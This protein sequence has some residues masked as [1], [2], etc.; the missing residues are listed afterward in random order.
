MHRRLRRSVRCHWIRKS[1]PCWMDMAMDLWFRK[2][3]IGL[4]KEADAALRGNDKAAS[5]VHHFV[6]RPA[7]SALSALSFAAYGSRISGCFLHPFPVGRLP[8]QG[9]A[10][11][12]LLHPGL[13]SFPDIYCYLITEWTRP[14]S[15]LV[16]TWYGAAMP[17]RGREASGRCPGR[18]SAVRREAPSGSLRR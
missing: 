6:A 11:Q 5:A 17:R 7:T 10:A 16:L 18:A 9:L 1:N 15:G 13:T 14:W 3:D 12:R 2:D 8:G 4:R